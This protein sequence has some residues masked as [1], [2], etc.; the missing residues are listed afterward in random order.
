MKPSLACA[1]LA[2]AHLVGACF[3][4]EGECESR[5]VRLDPC[6]ILA[7]AGQT[8]VI[9]ANI[10][11]APD[12]S[13]NW[14]LPATVGNA[15]GVLAEPRRLTL[16]GRQNVSA[17]FPLQ[18]NVAGDDTR[19][20]GAALQVN[21]ASFGSAPPPFLVFGG[22][23]PVGSEAMATAAGG[24]LYYVAYADSSSGSAAQPEMLGPVTNFYVRQLDIRTD[25]VLNTITGQFLQ[26]TGAGGLIEP[27]IAADC[28][29]NG[30]WV[31]F[32]PKQGFVLRRLRPQAS[33]PDEQVLGNFLEFPRQTLTVACDGT[34]Y[35]VAETAAGGTT[36]EADDTVAAIELLPDN[37]G[38][39][40]GRFQTY[41]SSPL[42]GIARLRIDG[43]VDGQFDPA[44]GVPSGSIV[45]SVEALPSGQVMVGGDFS[46]FAGVPAPG[47]V[48][49]NVDGSVDTT[50]TPTFS[51]GVTVQDIELQADGKFLVVG[52]DAQFGLLRRFEAN[53]APDSTFFATANG[54][55][56]TVDVQPDGRIL[57]GGSFTTV[58]NQSRLRLAR[59]NADGTLDSTF[60]PLGGGVDLEVHAVLHDAQHAQTY[61]AGEFNFIGSISANRLLRLG[62]DGSVDLSFDFGTG[63]RYAN[64]QSPFLYS[65]ALQPD[66]RLLVGGGFDRWD[67][68]PCGNVVRLESTGALDTTFS[69][70]A[71]DWV[72]AIAL[73][74]DGKI[75][76]GGDFLT[77]NGSPY[78]R[79]VRLNANGTLDTGGGGIPG[80]QL[81]RI[82]SFGSDPEYVEPDADKF[83]Q[84]AVSEAD[85]MAVD[86]LGRLVIGDRNGF[87]PITR[88]LIRLEPLRVVYDDTFLNSS[89]FNVSDLVIDSGD[90]IFVAG[91]DFNG[92]GNIVLGTDTGLP[93][94]ALAVEQLPNDPQALI[95]LTA[96]SVFGINSMGEVFYSQFTYRLACTDGCPA[97]ECDTDIPF[98][99]I[100]S[101]GVAGN[102]ALRIIDNI[103]TD[104]NLP[105]GCQSSLRIVV[106]NPE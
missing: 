7:R 28:E 19:T 36:T 32:D 12:A 5:G 77:V 96:Q 58:N 68:T 56:A 74:A 45:Y 104:P 88:L 13:V 92:G 75:V 27:N 93:Q 98:T 44:G 49:L 72:L 59:L 25:E 43:T 103:S 71:D 52:T 30:Y 10:D 95:G 20:G 80:R 18:A 41:D 70:A 2:A 22:D 102:G 48:R 85:C 90:A 33:E 21:S 39:I 66:G 34:I 6:Q 63:P 24:N 1:T 37:R 14:I 81:Y 31:D 29:G 51:A 106:L 100:T 91:V 101:L 57:I 105:I 47:L 55:V 61:V 17:I 64:Q 3:V 76:L 8:L 67:G 65:L 42:G 89:I 60:L 11:G 86:K 38:Y 94:Q 46:S 99:E 16:V 4:S 35:Y 50:F 73:Q 84:I 82:D 79:L 87:S 53:G 23:F 15:F 83:T 78:D 26:F 9:E 97:T 40:G 69:G 62:A 54:A